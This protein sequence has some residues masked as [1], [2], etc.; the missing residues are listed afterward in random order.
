MTAPRLVDVCRPR[1][2]GSGYDY[3]AIARALSAAQRSVLAHLAAGAVLAPGVVTHSLVE[4][5]LAV[6]GVPPVLSML[7]EAVLEHGLAGLFD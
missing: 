7:G 5:G 2:D 1:D 4:A 6:A 3:A